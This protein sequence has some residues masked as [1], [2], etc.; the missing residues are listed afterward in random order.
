MGCG[1]LKLCRRHDG[2]P[3]LR[4]FSPRW[5]SLRSALNRANPDIIY[6][7][8]GDLALGQIVQWAKARDKKV[9]YAVVN[10]YACYR[11]LPALQSQRERLLYQYGLRRAD[12]IIVQTRTQQALIKDEWGLSSV[13]IPM[14]SDGINLEVDLQGEAPRKP[15]T[16]SVGWPTQLTKTF[17]VA[18][19]YCDLITRSCI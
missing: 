16:H 2:L 14:Y 7:S 12:H 5:R 15:K 11:A 10:D 13:M 1:C 9:C 19:G 8:C 3:V 17:G 18:L 4:F 6:Y